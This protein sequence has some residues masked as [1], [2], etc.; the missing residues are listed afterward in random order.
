MPSRALRCASV[1]GATCLL[2]AKVLQTN[3]AQMLCFTVPPRTASEGPDVG[4]QREPPKDLSGISKVPFPFPLKS[5]AYWKSFNERL[6]DGSSTNLILQFQLA[7]SICSTIAIASAL[8]R[9][10]VRRSKLW[11]DEGLA[12]CSLL[13]LLVQIVGV[14]TPLSPSTGVLRYY[15]IIGSFYVASWYSPTYVRAE[16]TDTNKYSL[17][18]PI[19]F[20]TRASGKSAKK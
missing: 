6:R 1:L 20:S 18:L 5:N 9:L 10:F 2:Q 8:Y 14:F 7:S 17:N 15:I 11:F 16:S 4:G 12:F 13:A 3:Q 19:T